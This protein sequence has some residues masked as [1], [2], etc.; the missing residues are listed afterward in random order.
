M[1]NRIKWWFPL[2]AAAVLAAV[3]LAGRQ[4][5]LADG[6]AQPPVLVIDPGHGGADGGAVAA[7][8][9]LESEINLDIALRLEALARFWGLDPVMTRREEAIGYPA[10][11]DT[12]AKKKVADQHARLALINGTPGAVLVSIHQN[13][14][15]AASPSG[16]QVFYN[17]APGA[18]A[19][20]QLAQ[21]NLTAHLL[22]GN[23]RV[24]APADPG[25]F[26]MKR[27]TCPAI[28]AECGFLSNPGDLAKLRTPEYR[29]QLAVV[30]LGSY[31]QYIRG[32]IT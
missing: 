29:T 31:L 27:T 26:L 16:I 15:P 9:T 2:A 8:G 5:D 24:A 12:I 28:L 21:G 6:A 11:A 1:A 13:N 22:P 19:F 3:A 4:A 30:L 20:A 23:R 32:T 25:V 17:A 7:D 10:G 14:Y 18:D